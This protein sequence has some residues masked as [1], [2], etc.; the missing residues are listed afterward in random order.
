MFPLVRSNAPN[1][2]EL[3][4]IWLNLPRADKMVEPCFAMLW[5]ETIPTIETDGARVRVVAGQFGEA[6][7][8]SP[9]PKSWAAHPESDLAI[10]PIELKPGATIELPRAKDETI[11]ALYFFEG[12]SL[13]VDDETLEG[14][15]LVVC[16]NDALTLRNGPTFSEVLVL[17]GR[18]I[19]EPVA[20]HGPFVMTTNAEIREA[21]VDYQRT[22]YGTWPWKSDA[23]VHDRTSRRFAIH[24]DGRREAP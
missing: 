13:D 19:G 6:H 10:W 21:I 24:A 16:K 20:H 2:T 23:P 14:G 12:D 3:F 22:G 15:T 17:Q 1:P 4:Q 7:A 18:P 11:R 9:P 5:S 8:P